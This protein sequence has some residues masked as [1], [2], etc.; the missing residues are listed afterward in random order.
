MGATNGSDLAIT[1]TRLNWNAAAQPACTDQQSA[2][3]FSPPPPVGYKKP[4]AP[5]A[6]T[7]VL[8]LASESSSLTRARLVWSKQLAPL[9]KSR[10]QLQTKT[11]GSSR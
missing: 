10:D 2:C 5:R 1:H 8:L 4:A 6:Q 7:T 9:V 3:P 11:V